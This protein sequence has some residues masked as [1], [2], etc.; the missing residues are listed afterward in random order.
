[1]GRQP[2]YTYNRKDGGKI[3]CYGTI[4]KDSSFDVLC[5]DELKDITLENKNSLNNWKESCIYL[6]QSYCSTIIEILVC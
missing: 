3:K 1:M 5:E 4:E 2:N 6:E